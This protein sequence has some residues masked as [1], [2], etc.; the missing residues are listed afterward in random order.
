M[1]VQLRTKGKLFW[2]LNLHEDKQSLSMGEFDMSIYM[3]IPI[4]VLS[5]FKLDYV[6]IK[7]IFDALM[8]LLVNAGLEQVKWW[9]I[10]FG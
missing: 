2:N 3:Y 8:V 7:C 5:R 9:E 1:I 6:Q 10:A 4:S